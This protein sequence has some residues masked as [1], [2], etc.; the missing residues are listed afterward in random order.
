MKQFQ[1]ESMYRLSK[2][3]PEKF[4][5]KVCSDT[6]KSF[7]KKNTRGNCV[8]FFMKEPLEGFL[9]EPLENFPK[10]LMEEL[11]RKFLKELQNESLGQAL[12]EC[13]EEFLNER[14]EIF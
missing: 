5:R 14:W 6:S 9:M 2:R 13:E 7:I 10:K 8:R 4:G 11:F 1:K 12:D 3:N